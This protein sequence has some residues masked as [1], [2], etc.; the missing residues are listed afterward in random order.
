MGGKGRDRWKGEG[1]AKWKKE[2]RKGGI[3]HHAEKKK[4]NDTII[5]YKRW[6]TYYG[7]YGSF[8]YI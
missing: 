1:I 2:R 5:K 8:P 7:D 6:D 4:C 3:R